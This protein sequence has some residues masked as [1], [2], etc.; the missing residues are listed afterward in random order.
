[1]LLDELGYGND[2]TF[3]LVEILLRTPTLFDW[4]RLFL[5]LLDR[6]MS[7]AYT[8]YALSDLYQSLLTVISSTQCAIFVLMGSWLYPS[9]GEDVLCC[10]PGVSLTISCG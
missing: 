1:M 7:I 9:I 5:P 6:D 4:R 10:D 3:L 2:V 8:C